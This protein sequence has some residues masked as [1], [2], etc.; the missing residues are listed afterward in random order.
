MHG[1]LFPHIDLRNLIS[2]RDRGG[3]KSWWCLKVGDGSAILFSV[4]WFSVNL[5]VTAIF[6]WFCLWRSNFFGRDHVFLD[7]SS[8]AWPPTVLPPDIERKKKIYKRLYSLR[9]AFTSLIF[10]RATTTHREEIQTTPLYKIEDPSDKVKQVSYCDQM[11]L[12][13]LQWFYQDIYL[14]TFCFH[15]T[16]TEHS[17]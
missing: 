10:H 7:T 12:R 8:Q 6:G 17:A 1:G 9:S 14:C 3:I 4:V 2:N 13:N 16:A 11:F 15:R 5:L